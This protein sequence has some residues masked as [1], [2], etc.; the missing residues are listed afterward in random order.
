MRSLND[1]QKADSFWKHQKVFTPEE[2]FE[3]YLMPIHV[4]EQVHQDVKKRIEN[5][6]RIL[7]FAYYEY[8]LLDIANEHLLLT[9][10]LALKLRYEDL[11]GLPASKNNKVLKP[12]LDWASRK[13]LLEFP[14]R[15]KSLE[16][17]RNHTSHP[18]HHS[19]AG[20]T[21]L[22]L[23]YSIIENINGLYEDSN[24]RIRRKKIVSTINGQ[25]EEMFGSG[26]V[27]HYENKSTA[28]R[29]MKLM[30]YRE[31]PEPLYY[32]GLVPIE[33]YSFKE[34]ESQFQSPVHL[35]C[36]SIRYYNTRNEMHFITEG[37]VFGKLTSPNAKENIKFLEY[38]EALGEKREIVRF[39][40]LSSL[41]DLEHKVRIARFDPKNL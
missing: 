36:E 40:I 30:Y 11:E 10:E 28:V 18:K 35:Q 31:L 33:E 32:L 24:I 21:G 25:L 7:F 26:A 38:D 8:P 19:L 13:N 2:Y 5:V 15:N 12:L 27:L 37:V 34:K 9:M 39:S 23:V 4:I 22:G 3:K 17:L 20:I 6:K 14:E 29:F 41:S 1:Y 16:Y